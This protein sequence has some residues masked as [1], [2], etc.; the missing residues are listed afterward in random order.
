MPKR[1]LGGRQLTGHSSRGFEMIGVLIIPTGIGAEIGGH[2]GDGNPVAKLLAACCDTL[3]THPNVVNASDINEM[4]ENTLYVEGSILDRFL[5]GKIELKRVNYNKILLVANKP[6]QNE[7]INAVSASRATIGADIEILELDEPLRM[8]AKM[9][10]AGATGEVRGWECLLNQVADYSFDALAIHTPIE[11]GR[12]VALSYYEKGGINPWGGIEAKASKLIANNLNKPVAHAPLENTSA[13]DN[14][15]YFIFENEVVDPRMAA[16]VISNCYLHCVLKGLHKAPRIGKGLSVD[17]VDFMVTPEKCFG[18]PHIACQK[19]G[20]QI[21]AVKEN[22]TCVKQMTSGKDFWGDRLKDI[23]VENYW[24]AA[25]I[26][27]S[28]R[29]GIHPDSARRPL[30]NTRIIQ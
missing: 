23:L 10:D 11:V 9:T 26:I 6:I 27:M 29:A 19:A 28:M 8:I 18:R 21:I 24:E 7:T 30:S 12:D 3:I 22:G 1:G 20:I 5:E 13:E 14:E 15:L 17:E 25:G 2:A 4:P 16:E